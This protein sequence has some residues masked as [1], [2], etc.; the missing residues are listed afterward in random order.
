MGT[1]NQKEKARE[2]AKEGR[3]EREK[4]PEEEQKRDRERPHSRRSD[5]EPKIMHPLQ[6]AAASRGRTQA[7]RAGNSGELANPA[8]DRNPTWNILGTNP[9]AGR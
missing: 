3:T 9:P 5:P 2:G 7:G 6:V 4:G 8:N 1:K